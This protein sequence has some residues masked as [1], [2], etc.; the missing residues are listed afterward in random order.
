[1]SRNRFAAAPQQMAD[2]LEW[3]R[4]IAQTVNQTLRGEINTLGSVT[5]AVAPATTTVISSS[6]ITP[7]TAIFMMAKT[8]NAAAALGG[9]YVSAV[10]AGSLT[11]THAANAAV[12]RTFDYHL[13]G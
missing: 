13:I 10:A 6:R 11:L 1:M 8:A 5:L 12:D 4:R 7:D 2:A 3:C 9:L